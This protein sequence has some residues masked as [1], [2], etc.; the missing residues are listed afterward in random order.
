DFEVT[1]P[2]DTKIDVELT[3]LFGKIVQK[4]SYQVRTGVNALSLLNT[5]NLSAG[6]YIFRVKNNE[7][8]I[9]R[10]VLKKNL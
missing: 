3:D 2:V 6:T 10:K 8:L 9:N 7:V 1:S 4:N 5:E